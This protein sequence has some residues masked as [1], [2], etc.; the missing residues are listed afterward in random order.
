MQFFTLFGVV[1][2]A[3]MVVSVLA[4]IVRGLIARHRIKKAIKECT[5]TVRKG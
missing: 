2:F 4:G 1:V 3:T 5:D